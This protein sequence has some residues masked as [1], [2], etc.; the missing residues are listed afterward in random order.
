MED[1]ADKLRRNLVVLCVSIMIYTFLR[2][3]FSDKGGLGFDLRDINLSRAWI[4]II[5]VLLYVFLRFFHSDEAVADRK[6]LWK[7]FRIHVR[8]TILS[9]LNKDLSRFAKKNVVRY[10]DINLVK[11]A[12]DIS[13]TL[14]FDNDENC[15]FLNFGG[16]DFTES[17]GFKLSGGSV[18]FTTC[19]MIKSNNHKSTFNNKFDFKFNFFNKII[20]VVKALRKMHP[21]GK[22]FVDVML[23]YVL[24]IFGFYFCIINFF[25]LYFKS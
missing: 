2:P 21:L 12:L 24:A 23:P 1:S 6:K 15:K 19:Y 13:G 16:C 7:E 4:S 20:V 3:K 9:S 18:I 5:F 17:T 14:G 25:T 10:F 11:N 22:A 8:E